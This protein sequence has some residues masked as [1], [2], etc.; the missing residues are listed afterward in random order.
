[1]ILRSVLECG[2]NLPFMQRLPAASIDLI[3]VDPPFVP[4]CM[5]KYLDSLR[6]RLAEMHRLLRPTGSLFVHLDWRTVHHV[7]LMLDEIFGAANFVNEII[8]HYRTGGSAKRWFARK[9]DSIL[10]YARRIGRHRFYAQRAGSY[11]TDGLRRDGDG[12]PYK[13]TRRGRLYFDPRGPLLADVWD[14]PFLSTVS[15]ERTGWPHQKPLALL[16]RIIEATTRPGDVVGDFFAG[17]GT[18]LVAAKQLGRR[19]VG[20]EIAPAAVRLARQRLRATKCLDPV[21]HNAI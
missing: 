20:C 16:V 4:N 12:R 13:R 17:S 18:T 19:Y 2:D 6:P 1:M 8:W 3:Y 9:H 5:G 10:W 7:R 15:R 21:S 11:R 14:I